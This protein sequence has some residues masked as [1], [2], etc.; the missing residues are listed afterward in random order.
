M[1]GKQAKILHEA[2]GSSKEQHLAP[3]TR[4]KPS[5]SLSGVALLAKR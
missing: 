1:A 5:A 3:A 4:L 2:Q